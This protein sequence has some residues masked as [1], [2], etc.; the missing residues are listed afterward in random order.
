MS[1]A[2]LSSAAVGPSTAAVGPCSACFA[3]PKQS[4]AQVLPDATGGAF[5]IRIDSV[6]GQCQPKAG[7]GDLWQVD[8]TDQHG[9]TVLQSWRSVA[10]SLGNGSYVAPVSSEALG[11]VAGQLHAVVTLT[12]STDD[13]TFLDA[14]WVQRTMEH[15]FHAGPIAT[16]RPCAGPPVHPGR[17]AQWPE[18]ANSSAKR[19]AVLCPPNPL[20]QSTYPTSSDRMRCYNTRPASGGRLLVGGPAAAAALGSHSSSGPGG[21]REAR[22]GESR[23]EQRG[24]A[25]GGEPRGGASRR[26]GRFCASGSPGRWISA[27]GCSYT[28]AGGA[29]ACGG[30]AAIQS[31]DASWAAWV[32]WGCD[33]RPRCDGGGIRACLGSRRLLLLGDSVLWGTFLD[34][35]A[36]LG[37]AAC[38]TTRN[39]EDVMQ[40][41]QSDEVRVV[42][43]PLFGVPKRVGMDNLFG[44][45]ETVAGWELA[46]SQLNR[47]VVVANSGMHD[48]SLPY[49]RDRVA[50]LSA[51]Q[52]NMQRLRSLM[53]RSR[54]L[55]PSLQFVLR[56][57][58]HFPVP[59]GRSCVAYGYANTH[60]GVV[61]RLN[62][63]ARQQTDLP[64]RIPFWEEPAIMTY[65]APHAC[66][67]DVMHHD[68][69][70]LDSGAGTRVS[71]VVTPPAWPGSRGWARRG[72]LSEAVTQSLFW[73]PLFNEC[74]CVRTRVAGR[75]A[76]KRRR[77]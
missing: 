69:W 35:C 70:G 68:C 51:Y 30:R 49:L 42:F 31:N 4:T 45:A 7:E 74:E 44:T 53:D 39:A 46:F 43:V 37:G 56:A 34:L 60:A 57:T 48:V 65:S 63:I 41:M 18:W 1:L 5:F 67:R 29:R 12:W 38:G 72:G 16:F 23:G 26:E 33:A 62:A 64:P 77:S 9:S 25:P 27:A 50:P 10:R 19:G 20:N 24:S 54:A 2:C 32:P 75:G 21:T 73:L 59:A 76:H 58:S 22:G 17:L 71:R 3:S 55:N 66:F 40:L 36:T 13:P 14:G 6:S 61:E 8:F 28:R 15:Q 47:T 52:D 11:L